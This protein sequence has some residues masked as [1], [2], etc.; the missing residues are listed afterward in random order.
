MKAWILRT[1]NED[2]DCLAI[3]TSLDEAFRCVPGDW[4]QLSAW[5]WHRSGRIELWLHQLPRDPRVLGYT[6]NAL[7]EAQP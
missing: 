4:K 1:K 3:F 5:E 6:V 2:Q 7:T